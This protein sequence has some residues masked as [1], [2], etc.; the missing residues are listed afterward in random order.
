LI[1]GKG[2]K[3]TIPLIAKYASEWN[4]VFLDHALHKDRAALLDELLQKEGRQPSDVKRSLMTR[5]EYGSD[6]ADHKRRLDNYPQSPE[7]LATAGYIVG[8]GQAMVDQI[9]A[10]ADLGVERFMLQWLDQDNIAGL[11]AMARDVLP[12]FHQ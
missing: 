3:R 12:H 8:R 1:G 9:G 6:D 11:E 5:A 7:E 10:W 2:P 4:A